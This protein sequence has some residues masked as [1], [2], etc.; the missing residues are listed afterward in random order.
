MSPI[1]EHDAPANQA[2]QQKEMLQGLVEKGAKPWA[3]T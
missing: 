1:G 2:W 3:W